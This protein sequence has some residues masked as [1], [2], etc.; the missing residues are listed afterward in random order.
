MVHGLIQTKD[1]Q[2]ASGIR[3]QLSFTKFGGS[4]HFFTKTGEDG[5]FAYP[6]PAGARCTGYVS[7]EER[8][9]ELGALDIEKSQRYEFDTF[10][11]SK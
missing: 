9:N 1:G 4:V 8:N 3:V 11:L 7:Q 10:T 6:C 2:P 5:K